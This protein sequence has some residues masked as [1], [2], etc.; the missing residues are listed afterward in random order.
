MLVKNTLLI[1]STFA[2]AHLFI[3]EVI[4]VYDDD[5]FFYAIPATILAIYL[6]QKH[7]KQ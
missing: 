5:A 6:Y 7:G 3:A 1:F 4:D 2:V